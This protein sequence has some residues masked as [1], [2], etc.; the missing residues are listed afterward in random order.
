MASTDVKPTDCLFA[1]GRESAEAVLGSALGEMELREEDWLSLCRSDPAVLLAWLW[2]DKKASWLPVLPQPG[3]LFYGTRWPPAKPRELSQQYALRILERWAAWQ[4]QWSPD[5]SRPG[6]AQCRQAIDLAGAL[7][8]RVAPRLRLNPDCAE[9][10]SR[11]LGV[12]WIL[13]ASGKWRR[14]PLAG[15]LA[16]LAMHWPLPDWLRQIWRRLDM[17]M[18]SAVPANSEEKL[19]RW[20]QCIWQLARTRFGLPPQW[21]G[22]PL[23]ELLTALELDLASLPT[24]SGS[25]LR[26]LSPLSLDW[27][28]TKIERLATQCT[29]LRQQVQ[30]V[31]RENRNWRQRTTQLA[32]HLHELVQQR[33]LRSLAVLAAG[34]GHEL[35]SPL[36]VIS[37]YAEQLLC[38]EKQPDQIQ[39]LQRILAQTRR[40]HAVVLDLMFFA[41]PPQPKKRRLRL[42]RLLRKV[43]GRFVCEAKHKQ[44]TLSCTCPD[45]GIAIVAD[46]SL[47]QTAIECLL[48]NALE[49]APQGGRVSCSVEPL[50]SDQ[51]QLIVE[52]D[53]PG[54]DPAW[55]EHLFDPFFSGRQAGRGRGFGL[56]K[57]WRIAELHA[58][59]VTWQRTPR[60]TTQF[61][62]QLP[63]TGL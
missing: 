17:P 31:E 40:I 45:Q 2:Q 27:F 46:G 57:V 18:I 55:Q 12:A 59:R 58:G 49:A 47:L 21:T 53:G 39:A 32:E 43:A 28:W 5:W 54:P 20:A 61:V 3:Q 7:A 22:P 23:S 26:P 38:G 24:P 30:L 6:L 60:G 63:A 11:S 1:P 41:R 36:A 62:L 16:W 34:A 13:S 29:V 51:V 52:D 50:D 44:I 33:K 9:L 48:R 10:A 4:P 8:R 37:G 15:C 35:G 42:D 56:C 25:E 14:K 19:L